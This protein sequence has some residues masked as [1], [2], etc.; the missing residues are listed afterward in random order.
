MFEPLGKPPFLSAPERGKMRSSLSE[1]LIFFVVI[2][3]GQFACN[4]VML[5]Y[6][7]ARLMAEEGYYAVALGGDLDAATAFVT[8]FFS[9]MEKSDVWYHVMMAV[10]AVALGG[11]ALLVCLAVRKGSAASMALGGKKLLP[12]LSGM[13]L[14]ALAVIGAFGFGMLFGVFRFEGVTGSLSAEAL[15]AMIPAL[16]VQAF[17]YALLFQGYLMTALA[18]KGSLWVALVVSGVA[19]AAFTASPTGG[20][21]TFLNAALLGILLSLYTVR[22]G[23]LFGSVA[24]HFAYLY[25]MGVLCGFPIGGLRFP[26]P[27]LSFAVAVTDEYVGG[28][29]NGLENGMALTCVLALGIAVLAMRKTKE[30]NSSRL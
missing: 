3:V 29:A 11:A 1:L 4:L 30:Q 5:P 22:S 27:L 28:G 12:M 15:L 17:S 7:M 10:S 20:A 14:G 16:A 13:A 19:F 18:R 6:T 26:T 21:L 23:N 24:F 25:G 2:I 8:E 9:E